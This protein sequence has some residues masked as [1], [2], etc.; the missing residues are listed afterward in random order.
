MR[1][2][3]S[4]AWWSIS[5]LVILFWV[6]HS[7]WTLAHVCFEGDSLL[8][9]KE[10]GCVLQLFFKKRISLE[11][12]KS[13][14]SMWFQE[15]TFSNSS[16]C[17][18]WKQ[19]NE[20]TTFIKR[21]QSLVVVLNWSV[22]VIMSKIWFFNLSVLLVIIRKGCCHFWSGGCYLIFH[23]Y[24]SVSFLHAAITARSTS[25]PH[26]RCVLTAGGTPSVPPAG[27]EGPGEVD[28]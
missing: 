7:F 27:C 2:L 28:C 11:D 4:F 26:S 21:L 25:T 5:S 3:I 15:H 22:S 20:K 9:S 13:L 1:T 17:Y 24:Q 19:T 8:P 6:G 10:P 16:I 23:R 14:F 18:S 12:W